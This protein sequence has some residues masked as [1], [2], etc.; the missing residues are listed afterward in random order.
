PAMKATAVHACAYRPSSLAAHSAADVIGLYG[1]RVADEIERLRVNNTRSI[2][3]I[4]QAEIGYVQ[5][6]PETKPDAI[7]CE[8]QSAD[9]W[10]VLA[11]ILTP[12]RVAILH[13]TGFV[14]PGRAPNYWKNYPLDEFEDAAIA[15]ELLTILYDVYGFDGVA[16]LEILTEKSD[17]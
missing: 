6:A 4:L 15:N 13:A 1:K 17:S 10:P 7:Y 16:K 2:F 12:D 5:C 8:A 9:S 11:S 3:L 14:D